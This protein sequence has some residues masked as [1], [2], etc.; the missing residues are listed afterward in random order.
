MQALRPLGEDLHRLLD[1]P[2]VGLM[3]HGAEYLL[4]PYRHLPSNTLLLLRGPVPPCG[5]RIVA[6]P[7][8]SVPKYVS[9]GVY[10]LLAQHLQEAEDNPALYPF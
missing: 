8:G 10:A 6:V 1:L 3:Q 4:D 5:R 2:L 7:A 9:D